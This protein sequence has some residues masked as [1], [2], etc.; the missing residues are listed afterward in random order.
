MILFEPTCGDGDADYCEDPPAYPDRDILKK[1]QNQNKL[2]KSMFE[3]E[4]PLT[5]TLRKL[6][7]EEDLEEE[8][9]NVCEMET[10][11]IKP[12]VAKNTKGK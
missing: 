10:E 4:E 5:L 3:K 8:L 7:L 2:I 12:R 11:L 1:I 6:D 9:E